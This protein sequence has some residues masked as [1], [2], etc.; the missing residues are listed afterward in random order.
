[1]ENVDRMVVYE[2]PGNQ[3]W[4]S[5]TKRESFTMMDDGMICI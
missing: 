3:H 5:Q 4:K 2:E 1:M